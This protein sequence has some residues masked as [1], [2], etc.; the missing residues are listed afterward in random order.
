VSELRNIVHEI[1][2]N[3]SDGISFLPTNAGGDLQING[4]VYS[5]KYKEIKAQLGSY[6]H[7]AIYK[8]DD[9]GEIYSADNFTAI[10]TDP[11]VYV[12]NLIKFDFYGVVAKQT[13]GSKKFISE[14][15]KKMNPLL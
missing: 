15:Y 9:Y 6:Y 2:N 12:E 5:R 1:F 3:K 11:R 8:A 10:L 13:T 14:I 4:F 7:I